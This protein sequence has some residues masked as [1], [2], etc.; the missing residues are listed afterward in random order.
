MKTFTKEMIEELFPKDFASLVLVCA[1][2]GAGKSHLTTW[3]LSQ[4]GLIDNFSMCVC[5]SPTSNLS[6]NYRQFPGIAI[7]RHPDDLE[8]TIEEIKEI[9]MYI[10]E[11]GKTPGNVLL[12]MDDCLTTSTVGGLQSAKWLADLVSIRRHLKIHIW[13]LM[14]SSKG[15]TRSV[16]DQASVVICVGPPRTMEDREFFVKSYMMREMRGSKK[17]TMELANREMDMAFKKPWSALMIACCTQDNCVENNCYTVVA[18]P[19]IPKYKMKLKKMKV[20]TVVK[21]QGVE[22]IKDD[23]QYYFQ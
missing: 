16:R 8:Q 18:P 19:K 4:K 14:Q 20:K 15:I 2:A 23:E 22:D 17:E 3:L 10:M 7:H 11:Q 21:K 12:L 6:K 5:V 9:Q 13:M 1:R